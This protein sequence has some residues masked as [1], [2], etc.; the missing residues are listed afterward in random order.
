MPV[1]PQPPVAA[2]PAA[3]APAGADRAAGA[4]DPDAFEAVYREHVGRVHALC[5]RMTGDAR[6]AE[7]LTQDVF[8]RAWER[9]P[10]FRGES[11]LGTWLHRLAVN[12]VLETARGTRRRERRVEPTSD[13]AALAPA[14]GAAGAAPDERIA[15]DMDLERAIAGLP[16]AVRTVFVLHDIEGYRHDE[17]A[18]LT[19]GAVGTMRSQLHRARRLLMEALGR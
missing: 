5:L 17:I 3:P 19:G 7:E 8:V 10:S 14:S 6:E 2:A 18:R 16:R 9:L 1:D 4:R 13:L 12:V 11:A 15:L